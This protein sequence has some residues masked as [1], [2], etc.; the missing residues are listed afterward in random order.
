M[1]ESIDMKVNVDSEEAQKKLEALSAAAEPKKGSKT[2]EFWITV[3]VG[4]LAQVVTAYGLYKGND[5]V[6]GVGAVMT[7]V[8]GGA[9]TLSR[10]KAKGGRS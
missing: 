5:A 1:K 2:T 9:Y 8:A 7:S 6:V 10:G 3:V 4:V